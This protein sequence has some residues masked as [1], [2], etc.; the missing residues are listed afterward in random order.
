[1]LIKIKDWNTLQNNKNVDSS[2]DIFN[3]KINDLILASILLIITHILKERT[4]IKCKLKPW[5]SL[6]L[7]T[8]IRVREKM[9]NK[10]RYQLFEAHYK[11][12]LYYL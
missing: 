4:I 2:V 12:I 1:M 6:G 5:I 10:M 11:K 7:I 9:Y 3:N 8:F